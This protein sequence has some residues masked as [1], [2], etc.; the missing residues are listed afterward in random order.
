MMLFSYLTEIMTD[1]IWC[2]AHTESPI[3]FSRYCQKFTHLNLV[4]VTCVL[5][6]KHI[7]SFCSQ[8][9][10]ISDSEPLHLL[11]PLSRIISPLDFCLDGTFSLFWN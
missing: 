4:V 5:C 2:L 6:S 8:M 11:F 9:H 3:H 1:Y 10:Q 7:F